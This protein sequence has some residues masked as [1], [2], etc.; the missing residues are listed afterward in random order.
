V[1]AA[2]R[3]LELDPL[4]QQKLGVAGIYGLENGDVEAALEKMW[5]VRGF[6][7]ATAVLT[8]YLVYEG[9]FDEAERAARIDPALQDLLMTLV[10][11]ARSPAGSPERLRGIEVA[12]E[13]GL[14]PI[15]QG[16][17]TLQ[18]PWL[19]ILGE[20]EMALDLF[21]EL[22][23]GPVIGL[24]V[25]YIPMYDPIRDHPRFQ[26]VWDGLNLPE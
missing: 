8:Q 22:F 15:G 4:S 7:I 2:N 9:R 5:R 21:E 25:L 24:E 14:L 13:K 18:P 16:G 3:S 12:G 10:S 11:A 1:D 20:Q 17:G 19:V 6:P 23:D 26:A